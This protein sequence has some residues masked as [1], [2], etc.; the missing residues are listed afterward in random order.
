MTVLLYLAL[1]SSVAANAAQ[2]MVQHYA[3]GVFESVEVRVAELSPGGES[4]G[5]A[6]PASGASGLQYPDLPECSDGIDN[7]GDGKVDHADANGVWVAGYGARC[8]TICGAYNLDDSENS[9]GD[10]CTSG[11]NV[12]AE[13]KEQHGGTDIYVYG[14]APGGCNVD[15]DGVG[16]YDFTHQPRSCR[17]EST[18]GGSAYQECWYTGPLTHN[19]KRPG[20]QFYSN[21]RVDST[22]HTMAC[23]CDLPKQDTEPDDPDCSSPQDDSE[24]PNTECNDGVDNDG[25]GYI[26]Y[27]DDP[28]CQSADDDNEDAYLS[29]SLFIQVND[30]AWDNR[31]V[32]IGTLDETKLSWESSGASSCSA[33]SNP[34]G[35]GFS[36]GGATEGVDTDINEPAAGNSTTYI[37]V[38]ND[39]GDANYTDTLTV[40]TESNG[41]S[42]VGNPTYVRAGE[43]TELRW[44]TGVNDP[45]NCTLTG[46]G[47]DMSPVPLATG[48]TDVTV[49]GESTY[50]LTCPGAS[51]NV[52][53]KVLPTVQE[54]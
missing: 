5:F 49:T 10:E 36:T 19:C 43:E 37:L 21:R 14:C 2:D 44:D 38:C 51:D 16:T 32:T 40:T 7:D 12:I 54:T 6:V 50:T 18:S 53:I 11:E 24:E 25:D 20:Q 26:D 35:G 39:E 45:A 15:R 34:T 22:D 4:A 30:G 52:T 13:A 27:P 33:T 46:P 42:L 1:M 17:W 23:L 8:S 31:D 28:Q 47:L 41:V 3:S 9:N 29:A 48:D